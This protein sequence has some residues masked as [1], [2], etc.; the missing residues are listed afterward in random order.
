MRRLRTRLAAAAFLLA[1]L[2]AMADYS[3]CESCHDPAVGTCNGC[4]AH[5]THSSQAMNDV[6]IV[7]TTD[8]STYAPSETVK[9]TVNGGWQSG[10]VRVLLLDHNLI[11]LARSSCP[12]GKG[13]CTTSVFPVTLTASAPS[14]PGTY[15]WAVAWYGNQTDVSGG[16]FGLGTSSTMKV[17]YFTPDASNPNHGYQTVAISS[18]TVNANGSGSPPSGLTSTGGCGTGGGA[19][20]FIA[21]AA[22]LFC[23]GR[24]ARRSSQDGRSG[25][26]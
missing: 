26:T 12:G 25:L 24:A 2:T 9:V 19:L 18:F 23:L 21:V 1:P 14:T 22:V 16:S 10:W 3:G 6:N 7:G 13:G 15:T 8:A 4:H 20:D 17:G 11:E 5:G